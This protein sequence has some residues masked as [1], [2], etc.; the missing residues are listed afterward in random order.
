MDINFETTPYETFAQDLDKALAWM[1]GLGV[2]Y[3]PTRMGEYKRAIETLLKIYRSDDIDKMRSEY[4]R[5]VTAMYE[6]NDLITIHKGLAGKYDNEIRNHLAKYT[7]GPINYTKE[8]A[9]TS[10]NV[11]RNTA[12]ELL[13]L[14]KL[15]NAGV[16]VDFEVGSDVAAQFDNR[17]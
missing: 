12:F 7:K 2:R 14:E 6:A 10:S 3:E 8:I 11:G 1:Q 9:S 13:I 17:N 4:A 5:I 16:D 15:V